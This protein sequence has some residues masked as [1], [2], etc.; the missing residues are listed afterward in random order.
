MLIK[1][2]DFKKQKYKQKKTR[3][4]GRKRKEKTHLM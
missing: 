3:N 4:E 1:V 2:L